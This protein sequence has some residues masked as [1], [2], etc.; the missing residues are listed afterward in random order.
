[1]QDRKLIEKFLNKNLDLLKE[2]KYNEILSSCD[3]KFAELD[4][5][6]DYFQTSL[7][8]IYLSKII[9]FNNLENKTEVNS[10][11]NKLEQLALNDDLGFDIKARAYYGLKKYEEAI[12]DWS[13]AIE[14]NSNDA[15]L[16]NNRGWCKFELK[17]FE[18]ALTDFDKADELDPN[19]A[20]SYNGRGWCKLE[21]KKFEEA[22]TNFDKAIELNSNDA[23][24]YEGSGVCRSLLANSYNGRGWC[25]YCLDKYEDAIID[26]DKSIELDPNFANAYNGRGWCKYYLDRYE[27]AILD[28]NKAIELNSNDDSRIGL[29]MSLYF[30]KRYDEALE[31]YF[32]NEDCHEKNKSIASCYLYKKEYEKALE[33]IEKAIEENISDIGC[34]IIKGLIQYKM[35]LKKRGEDTILLKDRYLT[36]A[37]AKRIPEKIFNIIAN[38]SFILCWLFINYTIFQHVAENNIIDKVST[39]FIRLQLFL[40]LVFISIKTKFHNF[41]ILLSFISALCMIKLGSISSYIFSPHI[42]YFELLPLL[43]FAYQFAGEKDVKLRLFNNELLKII[44]HYSK[45]EEYESALIICN[46]AIN[47]VKNNHVLKIYKEKKQEIENLINNQK[48]T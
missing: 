30:L 18:E 6:N 45:L 37:H 31:N 13:K 26:L 46:L 25:K 33:Y 2:Q 28:F 23:I 40:T 9:V 35:G 19:Y 14:L 47:H 32:L 36:I 15:D 5:S 7:A 48:N 12:I 22:L 21:L 27:N 16:Y 8:A 17:K 39:W 44:E 3:E 38:I 24:Y 4:E 29:A 1:M 41:I 34:Y 43:Y 11:L 20:N 10:Y 42:V